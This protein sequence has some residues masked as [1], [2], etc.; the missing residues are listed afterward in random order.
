[1]RYALTMISC[2]ALLVLGF[3]VSGFS[4]DG[5]ALFKRCVGCHGA[6]AAKEPHVLKGQKAPDLLTK[7]KGYADGTYGGAQKGVMQNML[8]PLSPEDMQA[9][10]DYIE[11]L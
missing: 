4:A 1:M 9:L 7:M 2:C 11:K 8:K 5:A 10:A 6:D 3:A